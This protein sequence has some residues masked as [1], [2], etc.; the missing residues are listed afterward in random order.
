MNRRNLFIG[1]F[2]LGAAKAQEEAET[3]RRLH[4]CIGPQWSAT[5]PKVNGQCPVCGT[6]APAYKSE[7]SARSSTLT[8]C[9]TV[10]GKRYALGCAS[11]DVAIDEPNRR[12]DCANCNATFLMKAENGMKLIERGK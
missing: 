2:G 11:L 1:L 10:D 12:V 4:A 3:I 9:G 8:H 7:K 6:M 5:C